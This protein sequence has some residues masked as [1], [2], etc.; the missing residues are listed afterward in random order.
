M[1]QS[2]AVLKGAGLRYL[3]GQL[4]RT[5]LNMD[6]VFTDETKQFVEPYDPDPGDTVT[7]RLRTAKNNVECAHFHWAAEDKEAIPMVKTSTEGLF[8]YYTAKCCVGLTESRYYFSV[9]KNGRRYFYNKRGLYEWADPTYHFK[10]IPGFRTPDWAKGAVMYQ[11]F[12]D[13][14]FNGD[15]TNDPV[16]YEYL[17]IGRVAQAM[18]WDREVQA[19]DICNFYG[20]DLQGII[21]KMSYLQSLGVEAIYLNPIFVSPSSHKYDAQD[22]DYVDPHFGVIKKDEGSVLSFDK[23][24]NRYATKYMSRTADKVNLEASN[25]LCVEMIECAHRHGIKVILDG[26][27]NHCGCYNKWL[28][29]P[30]FYRAMGYPPGAYRNEDSP[31]HDYFLWYERDWP[32]NDCYDSW[33]GNDNHPKLNFEDAPELYEYIMEVGRKWVSPPYNADGWRLD[34]AADLGRSQEFNHRFWQD[35]RKAVKSANPDAIILAEHYGDV[36]PWISGG[37]WDTVMNYDAFMEPLTWFLTGMSKHS[38][39]HLPNLKCDAMAFENAMRYHMSRF[40][41]H[42]LQVSMNQLSNHDHSRFLTRT[43]SQVGRLHTRGGAAAETGVNKNIM[44]EAVVFQMTWPG[45]PTIYY[46][47]EAGVAGWT[48]PDNRRPYPWGSEDKTLLNLHQEAAALRRAYP[49]LRTGS[50]EFLWS[51]YGILSFGRWDKKDRIATIINNNPW[52]KE[53][54]LPVW[55]MGIHEGSMRCALATADRCFHIN[56]G[57]FKIESGIVNMTIQ[58]YGSAVLIAE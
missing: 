35:F 52:P 36:S 4:A 39:D 48:D 31:Y 6:A 44:M 55:K 27:F 7:F 13:R 5:Y 46:G 56:N 1:E 30:G 9:D 43:N 57:S 11:I 32:N 2:Q 19:D 12:V 20:G 23:F 38:E 15:K 54:K 25:A 33:W 47:D 8:D 50:C 17:Y 26:V 28:D 24:N 45:A 37:E 49:A 21:D 22:Y 14:F 16:N 3:Q 51:E 18:A 41:I 58:A 40:N 42:A 10:I 29:K 53:I 34:V